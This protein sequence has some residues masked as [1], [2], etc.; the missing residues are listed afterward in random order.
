MPAT[1]HDLL[2]AEIRPG[3]RLSS[4]RS[5]YLAR[6]STLVV[7]DIHWG[8]AA[9]HRRVGH[10]LPRWGDEEIAQRLRRLLEHYQPARMIWLGDSLH[11]A[12]SAPVAEEFL[13]TLSAAL[14]VVVLAGNHDRAWPRAARQ[15]YRMGGYFF[16]HGDRDCALQPDEIEIA[17]HIHPAV[18]W[19]DGAG[20]RLKVPALVEGPGRIIMPSF[21]DWSSGTPWNGRVEE[22]EKLWLISRR[23][24]WATKG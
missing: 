8:Y 10:L 21:S 3:W 2:E 1:T 15:H 17:G 4:E 7:A 12:P 18:A 5:L 24:I 9:S 23:R 20:L 19:S 11:T 13:A 6:E 22:G 14:E 16:H